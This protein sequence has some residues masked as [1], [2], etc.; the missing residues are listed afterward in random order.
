[1]R[2]HVELTLATAVEPSPNVLRVAAM[3]GLGID[4]AKQLAIVPATE[5]ELIGGQV[6][7]VTGPSGGGK[8]TL[9][10]LIAE[11]VG[12]CQDTKLISFDQMSAPPDKPLVDCISQQMPGAGIDEVLRIL[13][14]AGL[15]DAF[16]MLRKPSELSDGQRYRMRLA[17]VFAAIHT[18]ESA[19]LSVIVADEFG[20]TL[21]RTTAAVI[22]RNVRKWTKQNPRVCFVAATTHDDLL[23]SLEPD[24]LIEK[25]LGDCIEVMVRDRLPGNDKKVQA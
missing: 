16:V 11:S 10:R 14:R 9:V 8:S 25:G 1:M 13:S 7:F 17:Q 3:F 12:R 5:I 22:A 2:V 15:N 19:Q 18:S 21:D 4:T 23:E 20:S 24:V 6:V